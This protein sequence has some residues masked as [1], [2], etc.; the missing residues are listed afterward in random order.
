MFGLGMQEL[1][2]VG[3]VA[4]LLF[5]K[6]LPEV[7]RSLGGSYR[8]F[9]KGLQ[10]IQSQ[11]HVDDRELD[12]RVRSRDYASSEIDDYDEPTAPKFET[13]PASEPREVSQPTSGAA[14]A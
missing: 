6:R 3:V 14:E 9:R 1:M 5:G 4:V 2:I 12:A 13:P 10:E 11:M 7:M 8:E